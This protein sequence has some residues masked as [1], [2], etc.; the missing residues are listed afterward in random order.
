[1]KNLISGNLK[2]LNGSGVESSPAGGTGLVTLTA[3]DDFYFAIP[4]ARDAEY[5]QIHILTDANIAG[6]FTVESCSFPATVSEATAGPVDVS[7]Y[8]E[9]SGNWV[10]VNM[11]SAGYAQSVG[12]GWTVTVLSLA[13]TAG[14][15]G[16]VINLPGI[17]G[18]RLRLKA[19]ITTTGAV[20]VV[21]YGK[22]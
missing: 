10:Q 18:R 14:A 19:A 12:T 17:P 7:D 20:R 8:N 2:A 16:A 6:T 4:F 1:M 15:G 9:T 11:A 5:V 22:A 13:K 21:A 3:T